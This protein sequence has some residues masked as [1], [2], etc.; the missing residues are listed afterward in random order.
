[1]KKIMIITCLSILLSL[2]WGAKVNILNDDP[3]VEIQIDGIFAGKGSV[4]NYELPPGQHYIKI[5]SDN[6]IIYA[7]PLQINEGDAMKTI[8]T[9]HFVAAKKTNVANIGSTKVEAK[10][11][12]DARGDFA[13]GMYY[14]HSLSGVSFKYFPL[15][16]I[17]F[18]MIGWS[19]S[20]PG[21]VYENFLIRPILQLGDYLL[22]D[23]HMNT[24]VALGYGGKNVQ[25]NIESYNA[26]IAQAM[27]GVEGPAALLGLP[28]AITSIVMMVVNND[29]NENKLS[30]EEA[31]YLGGFFG[32]ILLS[33]IPNAYVDLEIGFER[34]DY[35]AGNYKSG[36]K[37][38][39][40]MHFYF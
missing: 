32:G 40:G 25:N 38:A 3:N 17:G 14:S 13:V 24:Y 2:A 22:F 12:R 15:G 11:V 28:L 9:S 27:F 10:R 1:M 37:I 16:N 26:S 20:S 5:F 35:G 21:D 31:I 18:Q 36:M 33:A 4:S 19:S 39:T 23:R 29:G 34:L 6:Q 8:N 30:A 7:E